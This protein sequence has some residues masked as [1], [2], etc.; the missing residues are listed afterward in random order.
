[1]FRRLQGAEETVTTFGDGLD[2]VRTVG[3]IA[4]DFAEPVNRP[5]KRQVAVNERISWPDALAQFLARDA[6]V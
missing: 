4:Q 5:L 3:R 1:L 2:E 6:L